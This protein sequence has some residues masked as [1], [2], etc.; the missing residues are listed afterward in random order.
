MTHR[1]GKTYFDKKFSKKCKIIIVKFTTFW[2]HTIVYWLKEN[3]KDNIKIHVDLT[4]KR[5]SLL[6]SASNLVKD[7]DR[8]LICYSDVNC[9][10]EI[11]WK[12]ESRE[13]NFFHFDRWFKRSFRRSDQIFGRSYQVVLHLCNQKHL[14][15]FFLK[16]TLLKK[17]FFQ[18]C[19]I[20][21]WHVSFSNTW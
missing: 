20:H 5:H 15:Y 4:R 1:I 13:D 21:F 16:R 17:Y 18:V 19:F 7:I 11:K 9:R 6:K 10:L 14:Q 12:D 3:M 2:H 8:V